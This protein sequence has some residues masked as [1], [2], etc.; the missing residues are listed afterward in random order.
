MNLLLDRLQLT[1]ALS[2][3]LHMLFPLAKKA[4]PILQN[5]GIAA[6]IHQTLYPS[7]EPFHLSWCA[8]NGI[9]P[10]QTLNIFQA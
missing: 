5:K 7:A 9:N 10:Q 4:P 3:K 8:V 2:L 1:A 6:R